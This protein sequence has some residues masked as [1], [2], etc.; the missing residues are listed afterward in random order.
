MGMSLL[1]MF[2][3]RTLMVSSIF[4]IILTTCLLGFCMLKG[5]STLNIVFTMLWIV[6]FELGPGPIAWLY[7]AE[8]CQDKAMS[9]ATVGNWLVN[10]VV[11]A[12]IPGLI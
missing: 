8:I 9:I 4:S 10:L 6:L 3:R 12:V 7:M 5:Y 2:G 1:S 11:S